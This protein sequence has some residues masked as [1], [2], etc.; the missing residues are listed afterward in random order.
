MKK[1]DKKVFS[2]CRSRLVNTMLFEKNM[3]FE[4]I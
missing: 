2:A 3:V 1:Y 4:L